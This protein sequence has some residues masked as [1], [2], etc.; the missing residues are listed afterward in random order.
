MGFITA[1]AVST[2]I[3]CGLWGL[4]T[5]LVPSFIAFAGF[6][7]TTSYFANSKE[8]GLSKVPKCFYANASGVIYATLGIYL[9]N[10]FHGGLWMNTIL[11][12]VISFLMVFQT[13]LSDRLSFTPG[14]FMGCF[15]TF[16]TG[17]LFMTLPSMIL[18]YLVALGC[19][20]GGRWLHGSRE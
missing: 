3:F 15:T 13:K 4:F 2:G 18:G 6:A 20:Y 10:R 14:A 8:E 7:G 9:L 17:G 1:L 11:T 5:G 16:A 12:G 19:D